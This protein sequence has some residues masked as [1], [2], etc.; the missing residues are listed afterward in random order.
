MA[1]DACGL[2]DSRVTKQSTLYCVRYRA[3]KK[4]IVTNSL[5]L[6]FV[7][8]GRHI[9]YL[10]DINIMFV[11]YKLKFKLMTSVLTECRT[12]KLL[13]R[14][15]H[16]NNWRMSYTILA[17]WDQSKNECFRQIY[18]AVQMKIGGMKRQ[19]SGSYSMQIHFPRTM[20]F[21][22]VKWFNS[23]EWFTRNRENICR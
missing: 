23:A 22:R 18:H 15:R 11:K 2:N 3:V 10:D 13:Y 16:L 20:C 12:I 4:I 5:S 1:P 9:S 21:K 6:F 8:N 17:Y 14:I 7:E 19:R